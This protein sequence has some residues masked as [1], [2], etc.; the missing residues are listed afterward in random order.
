[1]QVNKCTVDTVPEHCTRIKNDIEM[2]QRYH[3]IDNMY[4]CLECGYAFYVN[5]S[6]IYLIKEKNKVFGV[7]LYAD[8][9]LELSI[10]YKHI[11]FN[12]DINTIYDYPHNLKGFISLC[13]L[14]SIRLHKS[15]N[16]PVEIHIKDVKD[17]VLKV[18]N[19]L[20]KGVL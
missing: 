11:C 17:K 10:L 8:N 20:S 12:T 14:K 1:M 13:D 5:S 4:K 2:H 19:F 3:I 15:L 6:F 7:Y 18:Y 16:T 9:L